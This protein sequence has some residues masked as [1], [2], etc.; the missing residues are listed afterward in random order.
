[1]IKDL[2]WYLEAIKHEVEQVNDK[3]FVGSVE[4]K[5]NIR[6]GVIGNMNIVL[7]KSVKNLEVK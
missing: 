1:M 5:V 6:Q 7:S 3:E 2:D 4:F